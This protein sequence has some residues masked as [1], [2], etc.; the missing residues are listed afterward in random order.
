MHLLFSSPYLIGL[1]HGHGLLKRNMIFC[2]GQSS[3]Q[4]ESH[5]AV[6]LIRTVVI[7]RIASS[8][9]L[10]ILGLNRSFGIYEQNRLGQELL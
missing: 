3:F 6:S 10:V 9:W 1:M 4:S 2:V 5:Y 7:K 8:A